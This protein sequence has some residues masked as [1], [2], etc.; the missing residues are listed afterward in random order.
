MEIELFTHVHIADKNVNGVV[1]DIRTQKDGEKVYVVESD[2]IPDRPD[3]DS[4]PSLYPLF[5]CSSDQLQII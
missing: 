4:Y 5:D 1:V 3:P 2:E